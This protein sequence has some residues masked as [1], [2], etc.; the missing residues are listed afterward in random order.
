MNTKKEIS[1]K[2]LQIIDIKNAERF[3]E[4]TGTGAQEAYKCIDENIDKI[5]TST[6]TQNVF[7]YIPNS[8]NDIYTFYLN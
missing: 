3:F 8:E 4:R 5:N 2:V 1:K 7:L 6:C